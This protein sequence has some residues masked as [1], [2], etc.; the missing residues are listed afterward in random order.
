M[1]GRQVISFS[2]YSKKDNVTRQ[3][4]LRSGMLDSLFRHL[5]DNAESLIKDKSDCQILLAAMEH[6]GGILKLDS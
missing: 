2:V 1:N 3:T 6:S 4:E 5:T